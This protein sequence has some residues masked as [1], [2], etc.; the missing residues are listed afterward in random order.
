MTRC[1]KPPGRR[2]HGPRCGAATQGCGLRRIVRRDNV[3]LV[4]LLNAARL[5]RVV[6]RAGA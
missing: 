2:Q 1:H 6:A 3:A 5:A 4:R